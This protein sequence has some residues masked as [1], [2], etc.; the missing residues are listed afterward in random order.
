MGD[1]E[2]REKERRDVR[3]LDGHKVG[4]LRFFATLRMTR[5]S[6]GLDAGRVP[7]VVI[8]RCAQNDREELGCGYGAACRG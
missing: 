7:G 8:L 2:K 4:H 3:R 6:W 1:G 5:G